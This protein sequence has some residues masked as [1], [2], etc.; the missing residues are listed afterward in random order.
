MKGLCIG[1]SRCMKFLNKST[2]NFSTV[3]VKSVTE[4]PKLIRCSALQPAE[5]MEYYPLMFNL[6]SK[7]EK[8]RSSAMN[9]FDLFLLFS[10]YPLE[11]GILSVNRAMILRAYQSVWVMNTESTSTIQNIGSINKHQRRFCSCTMKYVF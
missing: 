5:K 4:W 3:V 7:S 1:T 2:K 8:Q 10:G 11:K 6:G 9:Q